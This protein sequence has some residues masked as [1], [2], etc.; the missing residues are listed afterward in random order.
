ML[1]HHHFRRTLLGMLAFLLFGTAAVHSPSAAEAAAASFSDTRSHWASSVMEWAIGQ[2]IATGYA[3]GSFKPN[4]TVGEQD[5]LVML[6]RAYPE[7]AL[8]QQAANEPWYKPA[9]DKAAELNWP[10]GKTAFNRGDAAALLAAA[11]GQS[12][13]VTGAVR[14]MLGAGLTV[15]KTS[16]TVDGFKSGDNMSRA[17]ALTFIYNFKK[18]KPALNVA[19][20][21]A[22]PAPQPAGLT[23]NGISL[24]ADES[25][26]TQALG[27]PD[28]KDPS[29]NGAQWYVYNSNYAKFAMIAVRNGKVVGLYSNAKAWKAASGVQLGLAADKALSL[30]KPASGEGVVDRRDDYMEFSEGDATYRLFVDKLDGA[31]LSGLMVTTGG[32]DYKAAASGPEA[33]Q[34]LERQIFDLTNAERVRLG[35]TTFTWDEAAAETGREHSQDMAANNYFA[36]V[37]KKGESPFDRME[38]HG[39]VYRSAAENIAAGYPDAFRVHA[40]WMNSAGHRANLMNGQLERLGVGVYAGGSY[41]LYYTQNFYTGF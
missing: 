2:R 20:V 14:W 5:F 8:R 13:S 9:Y 26:V 21:P 11:N 34:A 4:R 6:M 38:R 23:L 31:K 36:H 27:S 33:S 30:L 40:G 16:P 3:D 32:F 7:L 18:N 35:R 28:R 39:I 24:G 22:I 29:A 12:L 25:A 17:E 15:G 19:P 1:K 41:G 37:N 10:I